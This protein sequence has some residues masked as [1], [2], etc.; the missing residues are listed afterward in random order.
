MKRFLAGAM[1]AIPVCLVYGP[2]GF[3]FGVLASQARISALETG[4]MSTIVYAGSAQF[5]ALGMLQQGLGM[6]P[7]IVTTFLVNLRHALM[8]AALSLRFRHLSLPG[9][10]LIC[11]ELTDETFAIH[12]VAQDPGHEE[13]IHLWGLNLTSHLSW[14][15]STIGGVLL[16][17]IIPNPEVFGLDYAMIAMF[18]ALLALYLTDIRRILLAFITIIL[19]II[20]YAWIPSGWVPILATLVVATLGVATHR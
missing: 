20:G 4:L 18:A 3:A 15:L 9:Q 6:I 19:V 12:S 10:A 2:V 11:A 5:V 14:I 17:N 16:G 1:E 7:I 8:S 13:F